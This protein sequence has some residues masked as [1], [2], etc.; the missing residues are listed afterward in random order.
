M[1]TSPLAAAGRGYVDAV[2]DP[3]DTRKYL[4]GAFEMLFTREKIA[5]Q[6]N[7]EQCREVK[8]SEKKNQLI[9]RCIGS[10]T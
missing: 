2:I 3:K 7:M 10:D 4:V 1:Q 5:R 8:Q 6:K 9:N